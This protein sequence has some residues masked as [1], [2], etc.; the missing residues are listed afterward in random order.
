MQQQQKS[1]GVKDPK[2]SLNATLER[3]ERLGVPATSA[4]NGFPVRPQSAQ[5][6]NSTSPLEQPEVPSS[7]IAPPEEHSLP[8]RP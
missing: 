2:L 8:V 4:T 7:V 5:G 1:F 6:N 3:Y